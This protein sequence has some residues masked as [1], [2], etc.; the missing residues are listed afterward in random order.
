MRYEGFEV[1]VDPKLL[2]CLTTSPL[3][4]KPFIPFKPFISL[5][6]ILLLLLL[7]LQRKKERKKKE[8]LGG[9]VR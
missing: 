8:R 4:S 6:T 1:F 9:P 2:W 5:N 3:I 7:L